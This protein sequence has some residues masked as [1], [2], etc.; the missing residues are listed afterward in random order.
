VYVEPGYLLFVRGRTLF[1]QAFDARKLELR[2]ESVPIADG[3]EP[4]G[5]IGPSAYAPFSA[6]AHGILVYRTGAGDLTQLTWLDR[7]GKTVGT[8]GPP[9]RYD[10]LS[11]SPDGKRLVFERTDPSLTT[12]DI[13]LVELATGAFSR[14]TFDPASESNPVWS[15]DGTRIAFSA[16]RTGEYNIYWKASNGALGEERVLESKHLELPVGWSPDQ[17]YLVYEDSAPSTDYDF[18][19]LPLTGEARTPQPYIVGSGNQ[20]FGGVSPDGRWFVYESDE[21]G[22]HEIYVQSFPSAGSK[23][24]ITNEGGFQPQWRRDGRELFYLAP[25]RKIMAVATELSPTFHAGAPQPLFEAPINMNG[26][27]DSSARFTFSSDGQRVLVIAEVGEKGVS[28][29]IRVVAN[30]PVGLP[31][32]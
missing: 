24:Q 13:Y 1:A 7:H 31:K 2:S 14:F 5:E 26:I 3:V 32:K 19:L 23:W 6:S 30:W 4:T 17:K 9:G 27:E 18:W 25:N 29:G 8:L 21:T 28:S 12:S 10:Q 20:Q 11:L 15:A 22:R 16:N